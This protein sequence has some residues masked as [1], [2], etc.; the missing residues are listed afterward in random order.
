MTLTDTAQNKSLV[1][2]PPPH[3]KPTSIVKLH[4][5]KNNASQN[6]SMATGAP[7]S[8]KALSSL[9]AELLLGIFEAADSFPTALAL[10]RTCHRLHSIWTSNADIILPS[11]VECFPQAQNLATTQE[12]AIQEQTQA[13]QPSLVPPR[14]PITTNQRISQNASLAS[15]IL[16]TFETHLI[17]TPSQTTGLTRRTGL[18]PTERTSFLHGFYLAMT[19]VTLGRYFLFSSTIPMLSYMQMSEAMHALDLYLTASPNSPLHSLRS[20]ETNETVP[21]TVIDFNSFHTELKM[22]AACDFACWPDEQNRWDKAPH[23]YFT[24]DDG[25]RVI[26]DGERGEGPLLYDVLKQ[27]ARITIMMGGHVP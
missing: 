13:Q 25:Y 9:P 26:M 10:S 20:P 15:L 5:Q 4:S 7:H 21:E 24:L 23:G 14:I 22:W 8:T 1:H 11:I 27:I 2:F 3:T 19:Y 6:P 17:S 16:Q 18:T 12:N